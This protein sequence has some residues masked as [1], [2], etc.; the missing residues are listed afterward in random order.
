MT[1]DVLRTAGGSIVGTADELHRDVGELVGAQEG[2]AEAN[3]GFAMAQA[4][5]D[6]ELGWEQALLGYGT[7]IAD[8]YSCD[9]PTD[10][11]PKGR[12]I[13]SVE[14]RLGGLDSAECV[15]YFDQPTSVA[16]CT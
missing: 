8:T 7:L 16:S 11:G 5:A 1:P 2:G 13:A 10:N 6:C 15:H 9:D 4:V 14:Y 12:V 3:G